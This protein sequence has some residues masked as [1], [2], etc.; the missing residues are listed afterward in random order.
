MDTTDTTC[1]QPCGHKQTTKQPAKQ[2]HTQ[3]HQQTQCNPTQHPTHTETQTQKM[4]ATYDLETTP[5]EGQLC[6]YMTKNECYGK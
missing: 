2:T 6:M 5:C 1:R 4:D 3:T